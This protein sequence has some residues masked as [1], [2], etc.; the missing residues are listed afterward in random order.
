MD[1]LK[2][3]VI[4]DDPL[5]RKIMAA[6]LAG[7]T[8]EFAQDAAQARKKFATAKP[9]LCF[10]DLS[11]G[12]G[13]ACSGLDLIPLAAAQG[14]YSVVMSGHDS[15]KFVERAYELGCDDFYSKGN[16][17]LN[18]G[19]VLARFHERRELSQD[20]RLFGERF[21]TQDAES[22]SSIREAM[23]YAVSELPILILG[24][25]GTGKTRLAKLIHDRSRRAG[26][27]V[28]INCSAYTED[29][30]E[31]ELFGY[32]KGAFTG[33]GDS[34]KGKLLLADKG[35]LFLDEIGSMSLNMQTKLLKAVE[36]RQFYPLGS[37]RPETSR[38]RIVSAT[39]EDL[40]SLIKAGRMRFDFFQRIH[41]LTIEL[42]P[43]SRRKDDVLPLIAHF[44]H[45][46]RKLSFTADAKARLLEYAW[47][48]NIRELK[49]FVELLA[50]GHEGRVGREAVDRL[51]Q[52]ARAESDGAEFLTA[53]Q[54]RLAKEQ[55]LD[56][57]MERFIDE[58]IA[59]SLAENDGM[60]TKVLKDLDISTRLLYA[61]LKRS[62]R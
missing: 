62:G 46:G 45:G 53:E 5:A 3:L 24:P 12:D 10:I 15:E 30:L 61:S 26:E 36:E 25:S 41:G 40:Q 56:A 50:A 9:D 18:V 51:L 17:E 34:R 33:A 20:D 59:R 60:K 22:Q 32:R 29:L 19:T 8:V 55:G 39:L 31:A 58:A 28:A 16:E 7:H 57:A 42:K 54:Y 49:K 47:P 11:L 52:T 35:T 1:P 13:D 27:F 37:D 6:Q 14:A 2:I 48:G 44:T 38:F 23:K 4:D 21:V 43:L